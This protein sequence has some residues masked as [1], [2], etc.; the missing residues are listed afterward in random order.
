MN[1][2]RIATG[3][4]GPRGSSQS[5]TMN[6]G[7]RDPT[8]SC[9]SDWTLWAG[10]TLPEKEAIEGPIYRISGVPLHLNV[11]LKECM[12]TLCPTLTLPY[13]QPQTRSHQL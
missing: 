6:L 13:T 5:A 4:E 10:S 3:L 12:R 1:A 11:D 8:P 7:L 2:Q 9:H